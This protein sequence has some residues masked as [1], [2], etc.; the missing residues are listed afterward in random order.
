MKKRDTKLFIEDIIYSINKIE[1]YIEHFSKD[2]F[3]KSVQLQDAIVRRL[4]IIG[5]ATKNIPEDVRKTAPE[6]EWPKISG[7]RNVIIH[8][9]FGINL[10]RVWKTIHKDLPK[11]KKE[12]SELL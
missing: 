4:T 5:E 12:I 1:E 6:I 7:M 10:E 8:D 11:L 2:Q 3:L 9:Y